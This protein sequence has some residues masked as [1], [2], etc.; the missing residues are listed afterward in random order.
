[1]IATSEQGKGEGGGKQFL[2]PKPG[3][4]L[5]IFARLED[6]GTQ[7]STWEG[8]EKKQRK[9]RIVWELPKQKAVFKEGGTLEPFVVSASYTLGLGGK[10]ILR[11]DIEGFLGRALTPAEEKGFDL[12]S[13]I[14]QPCMLSLKAAVGKDG[15]GYVNVAGVNPPMEGEVPPAPT[16]ESWIF[17]LEKP[18]WKVFLKISKGIR[19]KIASSPEF[20]ALSLPPE[21]AASLGEVAF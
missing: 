1:M 10:F 18:D 20:S 12:N 9:I 3:L 4:S 7:T 17:D 14:G 6:L 15:K 19:A 8:K 11:R 21:V 16:V 13:L 2:L 5:G